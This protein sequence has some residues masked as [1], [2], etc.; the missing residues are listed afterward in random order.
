MKKNLSWI[1]ILFAIC[2]SGCSQEDALKNQSTSA[3]DKVFTASFEGGE[4]RT[5]LDNGYSLRWTEND[6]I[7]LFV[8][9]TLITQYQF[10]GQTGDNGGTFSMVEKASGTGTG[11]RTNYAV[12]P[13]SEDLKMSSMG[14][15]TAT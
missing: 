8:G 5:Q 12:Y 11:L 1:Y 14:V 3:D 4:S 13:Y 7:S 9:N 10:D 6:L 2:M 15:I